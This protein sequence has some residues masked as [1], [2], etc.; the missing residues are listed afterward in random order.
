MKI[1]YYTFFIFTLGF[2]KGF[3]FE[4]NEKEAKQTVSIPR[5]LSHAIEPYERFVSLG[6][7]CTTKLQIYRHLINHYVDSTLTEPMLAKKISEEKKLFGGNHLFDWVFTNN[8]EK[9]QEALSKDFKNFF[10]KKNLKPGSH[11]IDN[12]YNI[13]W[14]HLFKKIKQ[15][16]NQA[17][18]TQEI[19]DDEYED[20][21]K[22]V[23]Y[24]IEKFKDLKNYR[25]IYIISN[26]LFKKPLEDSDLLKLF[27][28]L[29][30]FR[31]N[32]NFSLLYLDQA[33]EEKD[34]TPYIFKRK[35]VH[36]KSTIWKGDSESWE[37]AL[38]EFPSSIK[39]INIKKEV[40][41]L[42]KESGQWFG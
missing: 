2:S 3:C 29:E 36:D 5:P 41:S 27:N 21:K 12:A 15:S 11:V 7:R 25:T 19:I 4:T 33:N 40:T 8:Y 26:T 32:N 22:K 1:V 30:K 31:G 42:E 14:N 6:N 24:L 38:K 16:S 28:S 9:V 37:K 18:V 13:G 10:S 17:I 39:E 23:D 34:I 20:K 35:I